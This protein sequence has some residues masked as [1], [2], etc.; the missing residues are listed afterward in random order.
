MEK[1]RRVVLIDDDEVAIFLNKCILE[2]LEVAEQIECF[3]NGEQ[4][5]QYLKENYIDNTIQQDK[6]D[7]FFLD[8][9]MPVM[10]GFEFLEEFKKL[11][12][13]NKSRL[14]I[15][16]LTSSTNQ[17]DAKQIALHNDIVLC[18]LKKPLQEENLRDIVE[19]IN[20]GGNQLHL[21]VTSISEINFNM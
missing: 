9:N 2:E 8:L 1:V 18:Y 5:I 20:K 17:Q 10:N 4:A 12:D 14:K 3:Y 15:V 11:N 16:I 13:I 7:L 6:P 19:T 21:N